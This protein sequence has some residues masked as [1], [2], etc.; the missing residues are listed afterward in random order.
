MP[1]YTNLDRSEAAPS[2]EVDGNR[3]EIGLQFHRGDVAAERWSLR[4]GGRRRGL[5]ADALTCPL[6]EAAF[7]AMVSWLA[8]L[9]IPDRPQLLARLARALRPHLR[10][11]TPASPM[12][13]SAHFAPA[14]RVKWRQAWADRH[15]SWH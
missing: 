3:V 9:H 15:A 8:V 13:P 2:R 7:D 4:R 5:C 14:S 6:P 1:L 11:T 12:S 10:S